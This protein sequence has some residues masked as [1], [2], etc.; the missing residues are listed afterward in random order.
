MSMKRLFDGIV[1]NGLLSTYVFALA[2]LGLLCFIY[3]GGL[4]YKIVL[5]TIVG[6]T[7]CF[8]VAWF[9]KAS[10]LDLPGVFVGS[11]FTLVCWL[12]VR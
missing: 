12:F 8:G 10:I 9:R 6:L 2:T 3:S 1:P 7:L 4:D 11:V 5:P